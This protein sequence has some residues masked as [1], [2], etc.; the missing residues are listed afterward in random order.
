M[1]VSID[2]GFGD[3]VYPERVKMQ[4]PVMLDMP[5]P[6]IYAYS[7]YSVIAEKFEAIVS[8]GNANSRY[9]DFYDIYILAK[10]YNL[11]GEELRKAVNEN[12]KHRETD[13][14][15]IVAFESEFM[16]SEMR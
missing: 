11:E 4:F 14:Y 5:V 15:D 7:I 1:P 3:L 8:L 9:K 2:I 10:H 13:F 16:K 6:D 12:F